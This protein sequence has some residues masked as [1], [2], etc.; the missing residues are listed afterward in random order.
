VVIE[1]VV[2]Q[3]FVGKTLQELALPTGRGI[4]VIAIK[5]NYLAVTDEGKNIVEQRLNDMP[6]AN[7]TIN[8]GDVLMLMGR[9]EAID[10]LI[11]DV[12]NRKDLL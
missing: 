12:A 11:R 5:Y 1:L 4:N 7:D 9:K 8:E 2:P 10:R 6:G 3:E